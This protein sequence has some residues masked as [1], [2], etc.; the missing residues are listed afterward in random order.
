MYDSKQK[1]KLWKKKKEKNSLD[2]LL[3][4]RI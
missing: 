3:R 4:P 2:H 1:F